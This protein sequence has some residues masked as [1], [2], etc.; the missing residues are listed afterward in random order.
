MDGLHHKMVSIGFDLLRGFSD[1]FNVEEVMNFF[2][3]SQRYLI[4][5][6]GLARD[7]VSGGIGKTDG[8]TL[9]VNPIPN[10]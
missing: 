10:L 5:L 4:E 8:K 9:L 2:M 1:N 7:Q 3:H 6:N